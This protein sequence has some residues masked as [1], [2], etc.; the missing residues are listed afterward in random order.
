VTATFGLSAHR[1]LAAAASMFLVGTV[2]AAQSAVTIPELKAAFVFNLVKFV[3]WP[4]DAVEI[5]PLTICVLGD[6]ALADGLDHTVKKG[7]TINGREVLVL[8]VKADG[9][10]PCHVLYLTGVAP[11]RLEQIIDELKSAPVLTVSDTDQ[12]AQEGGIAGLLVDGGKIRFAVNVEAS[13]RAR[14]HISSKLLNLATIVRDDRV[15]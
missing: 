1:V 2:A 11:R 14:L 3:E 4:G 6:A 7:R 10:R 13:Q 15:P 12:F 9:L 5:G 8:R